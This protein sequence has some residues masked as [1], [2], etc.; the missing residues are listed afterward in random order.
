MDVRKSW[1]V[2]GSC[3]I[4]IRP[5]SLRVLVGGAEHYRPPLVLPVFGRLFPNSFDST[6]C[7]V[8][9]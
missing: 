1:R 5:K 4:R 9:T 6:D 8:H 2:V 3:S 7:S